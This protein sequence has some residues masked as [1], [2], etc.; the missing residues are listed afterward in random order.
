[1]SPFYVILTLI[2][3]GLFVGGLGS[4]YYGWGLDDDVSAKTRSLRQGGVRGRS[5]LGGGPGFGK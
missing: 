5:Y 2:L 4:S 1:M 3:L